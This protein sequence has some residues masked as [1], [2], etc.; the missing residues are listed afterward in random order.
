MVTLNREFLIK[1]YESENSLLNFLFY[2]KVDTLTKID[3]SD[4]KINKIDSKSFMGLNKRDK[5]REV[6]LDIGGIFRLSSC[7]ML[8]RSVSL[9]SRDTVHIVSPNLP[10]P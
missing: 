10:T 7:G 9:L 4:N 2:G 8:L 3:V 1:K 6:G 5:I